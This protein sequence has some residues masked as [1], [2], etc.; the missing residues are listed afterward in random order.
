VYRQLGEESAALVD[1]IKAMPLVYK[2]RQSFSNVTEEGF[3]ATLR[4]REILD[5][6]FSPCH[7]DINF[8]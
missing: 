7:F 5:F 6:D 2:V 4:A 3:S 1:A 8:A